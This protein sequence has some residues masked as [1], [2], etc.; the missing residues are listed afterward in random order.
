MRERT[1][2]IIV[3]GCT[4]R[5]GTILTSLIEASPD[6]TLAAGISP[7]C[8]PAMERR[9]AALADYQGP[10]DCV[11]DFSNH[12][13]TEALLDYCV[14]RQLPLVIA[15]TGHT[16]A[17]KARIQAASASIPLFYSA[18][19]SIGV[20]LLASLARQTAAMFPE[21]DIEIIERH[22]NQ[23]LDVPSGT[24]LLLANSICQA[25]PEATLLVGRHENGKRTPQEIGI[26]SL[27]YG[28]EVGTHE[29]IVS[30]G[31]QTITLKHEAENRSLFA[32]GALAAAAFLT[33]KPAG[34]YTMNELVSAS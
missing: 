16:E 32:E 23:K 12:G 13:A 9:Y 15:T 31:T 33:G 11:I 5:M 7:S 21:A 4:G 30:T 3:H 2:N 18:N 20:A 24:A 8:S 28:S 1:M 10:A 34:Y 26:H 25:R 6:H 22:H 29:I 17:E 19:M 27:R 14:A